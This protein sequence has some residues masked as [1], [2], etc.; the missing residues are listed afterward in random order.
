MNW[1][2]LA[3][4]LILYF[5]I[6]FYCNKKQIGYTYQFIIVIKISAILKQNIILI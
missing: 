2:Q 3:W 6:S 1:T 5:G 4:L